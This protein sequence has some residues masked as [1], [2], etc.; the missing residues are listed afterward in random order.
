[1]EQRRTRRTGHW[2]QVWAE[3]SHMDT[4]ILLATIQRRCNMTRA[5]ASGAVNTLVNKGLIFRQSRGVYRVAGEN[6]MHSITHVT[7][8]TPALA[9][10]N[11]GGYIDTAAASVPLWEE[12][13]NLGDGRL[14]LKSDDGR[15][16]ILAEV[17]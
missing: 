10:V 17:K 7:A 12:V 1:M 8:P 6:R 15:V 3:V 9:P 11:R 13:T 14:L 16:G 2:A 5:E 4:P